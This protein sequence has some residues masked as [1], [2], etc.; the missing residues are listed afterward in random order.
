ML[1]AINTNGTPSIASTVQVRTE[2]LYDLPAQLP[3]NLLD[4]HIVLERNGD[5]AYD[6]Y[7]DRYV[8]TPDASTKHGSFMSSERVDLTKT[9]DI[10]FDIYV[11]NNDNG[12]DGMGFVLHNDP[13]GK[14]ALGD[15]GSGLGMMGINNGVGIEFDTYQSANDIANDHT[16]FVNTTSGANL[17][18]V[19][20]L[21]NI[22]D[23]QWHPVHVVSDGQTISYTFDGVQMSSLSW[24]T[25]QSYLGSQYAYFGFTGGT[26]GATEQEQVRLVKLDATAEDGALYHLN[27]ADLPQPVTFITNGNA[28]YDAAHKSYVV[29]PEA[30]FQHGSVMANTRVDLSKPFKLIFDIDV[31]NDPNGASGTGFV[32][33]NDAAGINALGAA[34]GGQGLIGIQNG[35]GIT[36]ATD[37]A[38]DRTGFV[39]TSDGSA[40]STVVGLGEI[41][42]GL[43]HR[44][45]ITSDGQTISYTFDDVPISSLGLATVGMLLG[46][47]SLAYWGLTGATDALGEQQQVRLV[48]MAATDADGTAY[49]IVGPNK[50]PIAV[51]DA[52]TVNKNGVLTIS[53]AAGVL[54]NDY[55]PDGDP[56]HI[57]TE[58]RLVGHGHSLLLAPANGVVTISQDGSFTYTPDAGF[59]GADSFYYCMQD[60]PACVQGR[61]DITVTGTGTPIN[62]ILGTSADDVLVGTSANDSMSGLAGDDRLTGGLRNDTFVFAPGFDNDIITDFSRAEGNRDIIDL[63]AFNFA[64]FTEV[65][66]RDIINGA[67]TIFNFGNG[68]TLTVQNTAASGFLTKLLVD[69][70]IL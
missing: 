49:Q 63:S 61:V 14:N 21:G 44:V 23:G 27:R 25:A 41:E 13:L 62:T 10:T 4:A 46:G 47:T 40:Q 57:C 9:F 42:D 56:L 3:L 45:A 26:G 54:A 16:A 6:A 39:K 48:K 59:A 38:T 28:A 20:D 37:G 7:N 66:S 34:G 65:L 8:L 52:Y 58:S 11:G 32:L 55:D 12:A 51:N 67:D 2:L 50:D 30:Q 53:A 68:D 43:W 1:F 35:L 33:H 17:L 31:G 70:F 15:A 18:P 29:T 22:E 60:G 36:F 5:A 19:R 64:S 24:A 69:D